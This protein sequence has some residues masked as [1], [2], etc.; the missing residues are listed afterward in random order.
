MKLSKLASTL[1]M[2]FALSAGLAHADL[3]AE[4]QAKVDTY[5]KQMVSWAA[6]PQ[7]LAAAREAQG[8]ALAGMTNA[9]W[10]DLEEGSPEVKQTVSSPV[11]KLLKDW[12]KDKNINKLFLRDDKGNVIAGTGKTM[13]YNASSRPIIAGAMKGAV[14]QSNEVKPD[15]S[16]QVKSVQLAVPV[17][18]GGKTIGVLS[19]AVTAE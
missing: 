16:T 14:A 11:S 10:D 18:D 19:T 6:S 7:V 3:P 9:K 2:G 8:K 12:E 5:K 1:V 15:P 13:L 17:L 4:V